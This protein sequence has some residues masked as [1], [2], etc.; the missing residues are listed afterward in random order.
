MKLIKIIC[1]NNARPCVKRRMSFRACAKSR[2]LLKVPKCPI[3]VV[4]ADV[5]LPYWTLK[6]EHIAVK[7]ARNKKVL[8]HLYRNY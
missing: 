7:T 5:D 3:A 2:D 8:S 6:V 4:L 1:E